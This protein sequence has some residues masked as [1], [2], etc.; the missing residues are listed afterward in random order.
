[1]KLARAALRAGLCAAAL[2]SAALAL[3]NQR[4]A[5]DAAAEAA[6]RGDLRRLEAL[7]AELD[8][9]LLRARSGLVLHYDALSRA[10]GGLVQA[11]RRLAQPGPPFDSR[12]APALG[13]ALAEIE[14]VLGDVDR[15]LQVFKTE[16]ALLRNSRNYYPEL[17]GELHAELVGSGAGDAP[18]RELTAVLGS[19][20]YLDVAPTPEAVTRLG[21][22][23]DALE[24]SA[25]SPP[26]P[27]LAQ[28]LDLVL[29]HGR[30]VAKHSPIVDG[31]VGELLALPL[32]RAIQAASESYHDGY[33]A[34]T[35][36]AEARSLLLALLVALVLVL[37]LLEVIAELEARARALRQAK[38]E[39][40]L[41]NRALDRE[42]QRE[43]DENRLKTRFVSATSHEFRTPLTTILS[44]SRMLA[45]YGE[46]W[47]SERRLSNLDRISA[48]ARHMSRLMDDLLLIGRAEVGALVPAPAE[49]DL[50]DF[51]RSLIEGLTRASLPQQ[52]NGQ[53]VSR[54]R[55]IQFTFRGPRQVLLDER[56]LNHVLGNLLENAIKYSAAGSEV[57]LHVAVDEHEVRC[58]VQDAGIGIRPEDRARVFDSF[59]RGANVGAVTGTGLGLAVAK[60]AVAVQKGRIEIQSELGKGTEVVVWLPLGEPA[61]ATP[62]APAGFDA[63]NAA[64]A[65]GRVDEAGLSAQARET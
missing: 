38:A 44:S 40:E 53:V 37:G 57:G 21:D 59:H 25:G 20:V 62:Q 7:D 54:Q 61:N 30:L 45:T 13:A 64:A 9:E 46:R 6:Y 3:H 56:L 24:R 19:L 50:H 14:R 33:R 22:A 39:L 55:D 65:A 32:S 60:R 15:L 34:A 2:A 28:D 5:I 41:A 4:S 23:L 42:R 43:Q 10:F 49:L 52:T 11:Q 48:A 29:R 35:R 12:H 63:A 58:V 31:L 36:S 47:D 17:L 18:T 51:C 27:E 26:P 16:N 8:R 1:V